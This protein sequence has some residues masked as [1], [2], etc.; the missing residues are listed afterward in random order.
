MAVVGVY[1][2]FFVLREAFTENDLLNPIIVG[3]INAS[4]IVVCGIAV[5][6][7]GLFAWSVPI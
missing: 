2:Y 6:V 3:K 5:V 4:L 7:L 1:Y